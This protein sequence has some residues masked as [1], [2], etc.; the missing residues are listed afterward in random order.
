MFI[1]FY[2]LVLVVYF[3]PKRLV[4][5]LLGTTAAMMMA[6]VTITVPHHQCYPP[7]NLVSV[8][9]TLKCCLLNHITASHKLPQYCLQYTLRVLVGHAMTVT[10]LNFGCR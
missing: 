2:L 4:I 5:H 8:P 6:P 9:P 1:H 3:Q 7:P 10:H